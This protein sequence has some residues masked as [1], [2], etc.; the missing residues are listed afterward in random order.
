MIDQKNLTRKLNGL[1]PFDCDVGEK[2]HAKLL[3]F[4]STVHKNGSKVIN[5]LL[6]E[7]GRVLED[8]NVL[9]D[10][11]HQDVVERLDYEK[12]QQSSGMSKSSYNKTMHASS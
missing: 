12:D 3:E 8:D 10:S 5:E 9:K 1:K 4:V 11:W 2:Q 6:E 7:G